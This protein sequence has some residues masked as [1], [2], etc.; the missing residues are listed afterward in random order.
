[1]S[2]NVEGGA[3]FMMDCVASDRR[4]RRKH[5]EREP[6]QLPE[7]LRDR[8]AGLLDEAALEEAVQGL[9]PDRSCW[10]ASLRSSRRISPRPRPDGGRHVL[11]V[12]TIRIRRV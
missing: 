2:S 8:V 12:P 7:K 10:F 11:R 1:M 6:E 5:S 4:R 9:K 3:P